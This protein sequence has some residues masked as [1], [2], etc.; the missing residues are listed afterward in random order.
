MA[1]NKI[2]R[3]HSAP[4]WMPLAS[5]ALMLSLAR[6][7]SA[8]PLANLA[9]AV[10]APRYSITQPDWTLW[11]LPAP[12]TAHRGALAK[13]AIIPLL[14][15][16]DGPGCQNQWWQVGANAWLCPD[17]A[18]L[19]RISIS[20]SEPTTLPPDDLVGYV[21]V[22]KNGA[23][24]YRRR[25]DIDVGSP[26][27]EMQA[28]FLLGIVESQESGDSAAYLT[29]HGVWIPARD[30]VPVKPS[31][32]EGI[33]VEG[34]LDVAWVFEKRMPVFSSPDVKQRPASVVERMT[35]VTVA[36]QQQRPSGLWLKTDHG[37]FKSTDL[38]SPEVKPPPPGIGPNERW[39]DVDTKSQTLIAYVGQRPVFST[40]V[41][42]GRG[43]QGT[44]Q[45]TPLGLHRLWIKL[46]RSDMDNLDDTETQ[47]PY[48]VEAVPYVMFFE[49][50]YGI[51]GTYWHDNF[52]VPKSHGCIN[53]SVSDARWLFN[54]SAPH[55]PVGWSAVF[56]T[57]LERGTLVRVR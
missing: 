54:F 34:D 57:A 21:A 41:S 56:P 16:F 20:E 13:G 12:Q 10:L 19:A 31:S 51:H 6:P 33:T 2:L 52:G 1:G 18:N 42:T 4:P 39:L 44:E 7:C 15:T 35:Q 17:E 36:G 28:G 47:A 50:G 30:V 27:A 22:G 9:P 55:L 38:R 5:V 49:R 11:Q 23:L 37:W 24:G 40:L 26:I 3:T 8:E 43:K 53:V 32:F 48:A 46:R 45:A 14:A 25:E 29:T